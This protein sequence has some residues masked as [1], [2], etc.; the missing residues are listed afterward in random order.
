MA[1]VPYIADDDVNWIAVWD[2]KIRQSRVVGLEQIEEAAH[3]ALSGGEEMLQ[4]VNEELLAK[5]RGLIE[6]DLQDEATDFGSVFS[7]LFAGAFGK[8]TMGITI[9]EVEFLREHSPIKDILVMDLFVWQIPHLIPSLAQRSRSLGGFYWTLLALRWLGRW[10]K[11]S[12]R[13]EC[14]PKS[15]EPWVSMRQYAEVLRR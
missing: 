1:G 2:A 7:S 5:A 8:N 6:A 3:A 15:R 4:T 10:N 13:N 12:E 11:K 14:P 9:G